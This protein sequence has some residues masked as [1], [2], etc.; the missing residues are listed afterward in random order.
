MLQAWKMEGGKALI[1]GL[2]KN[3]DGALTP[4]V[5]GTIGAFL[6]GQVGGVGAAGPAEIT[7]PAQAGQP[8]R[9]FALER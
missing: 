3:S 1:K 7:P 6:A 2:L 9:A 5:M 8:L 4:Q